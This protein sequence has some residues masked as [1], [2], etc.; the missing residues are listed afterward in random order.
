MP[1]DYK[2]YPENWLTEIRP[3]IMARAKNTCEMEGCDF[4]HGETVWRVKYRGRTQAW[5]RNKEDAEAHEPKSFEMKKGEVVPNPK[6]VK[7]ILTIAHLD[8]DETNQ[9]V[10]D[11]RLAAMCQLCHLRYDAKEKYKRT[12]K[13]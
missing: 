3:R 6:P 7:V 8:H 9:N 13:K 5:Y 1:I 2:K 4:K 12:F 10:S 11:D